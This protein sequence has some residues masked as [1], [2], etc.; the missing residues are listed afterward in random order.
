MK[1]VVRICCFSLL[2]SLGAPIYA[3]TITGPGSGL[4]R[5]SANTATLALGGTVT[6]A[7]TLDYTTSTTANFLIKKAT[8]NYFFVDNTGKVGISTITPTSLFSLGTN[9][10][11]SKLAIWDNGTSVWTR[12]GNRP[13]AAAP[14]SHHR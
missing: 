1:L 10:A 5:P 9:A 12:L 7:T 13:I 2:L 8:A 3:Q 4:S 11:N 6:G 14:F